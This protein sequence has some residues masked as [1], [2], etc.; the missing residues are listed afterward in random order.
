MFFVLCALVALVGVG[1]F[2]YY[3]YKQT[4]KAI[5]EKP[6]DYPF[7]DWRDFKWVVLSVLSVA[8]L[9]VITFNICLRC[10][11]PICKEQED[12]EQREKRSRK[13][14]NNIFKLFYYIC[15]SIWGYII[16]Y[17]KRYFPYLLGGH[18]DLWLCHDGFPY[19]PF[20]HRFGLKAFL[21]G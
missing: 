11:R 12:L 4:E 10:F 13:A 1:P 20:E 21:L 15:I 16:L 14:A 6:A 17:D 9:D 7:P 8:L 5:E 19:Q 3:S 2:T 18:G